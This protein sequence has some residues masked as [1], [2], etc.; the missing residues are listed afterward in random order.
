M[1]WWHVLM[2]VVDGGG[3]GLACMGRRR[4]V[5]EADQE[6]HG[7]HFCSTST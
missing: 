4:C 5:G 1:G 3:G 6:A 7:A 2:Y